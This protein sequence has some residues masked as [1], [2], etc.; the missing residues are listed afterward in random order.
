MNIQNLPVLILL[1]HLVYFDKLLI[2]TITNYHI[3]YNPTNQHHSR[4]PPA[5]FIP[6]ILP[7]PPYPR[8]MG[9][10]MSKLDPFL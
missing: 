2:E 10:I 5:I 6:P 3:A 8:L 4:V 7:P 9:A 1:N